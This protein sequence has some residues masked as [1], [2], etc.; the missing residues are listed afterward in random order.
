MHRMHWLGSANVNAGVNALAVE[1]R[2]A[3]K[4]RRL[5]GTRSNEI[6]SETL[7]DSRRT[8]VGDN[9]ILLTRCSVDVI[10]GT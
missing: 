7:I 4:Q 3:R 6:T 9:F 5:Y 8:E 10:Y 2:G 1:H